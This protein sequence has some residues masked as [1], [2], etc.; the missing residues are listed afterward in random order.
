MRRCK[1]PAMQEGL[2]QGRALGRPV[3]N[4]HGTIVTVFGVGVLLRGASGVGKSDLA[5]RL[6]DRGACLVA[7]DQVILE[8]RS[9]GLLGFAPDK[10]YGLL[11]VRG[12]GVMSLPA[13]KN[14]WIKLVVDLVDTGKAPRLPERETTVIEGVELPLVYLSAFDMSTPHKIELAL[15]Y[16]DQIGRGVNHFKGDV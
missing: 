15:R 10:L 7:D 9:K 3:N 14:V 5:L 1:C 8:R 11:E 2:Q 4:R 6:I 16:P 13:I 12:L